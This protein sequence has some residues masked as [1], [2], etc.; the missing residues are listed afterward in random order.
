MGSQNPTLNGRRKF[1][2]ATGIFVDSFPYNCFYIYFMI[3]LTNVVGIN[4][5]L[6]GTIS[7]CSVCV[8][9]VTDP[10]MGWLVDNPKI[11]IKKWMLWGG[12]ATA[13]SICFVF[14]PLYASTA[15]QFVYYVA[16]SGIMWCAYTAFCI[17]YY[18]MVPQMTSDYNE[19]T[20]IRGLSGTINSIAVYG[21]CVLPI[22][23]I[24]AISEGGGDPVMAWFYAA[25]VIGAISLFFTFV[26]YFSVKNV[27]FIETERPDKAENFVKAYGEVFR[28][29]PVKFFLAFVFLFIFGSAMA[30]SNQTYLII[31]AAGADPD[32]LAGTALMTLLAFLI[33]SPVATAISQK[34]DRKVAIYVLLGIAAAGTLIIRIIGI[35]NLTPVYFLTAIACVGTAAFWCLFYTFC[36]DIVALDQY[37][38]GKNREGI[39]TGLPNFILKLANAVGLQT[40]GIILTL[41]GYD[42]TQEAQTERAVSGIV[43][44]STTFFAILMVLAI[45]MMVLYPITKKKYNKLLE[46]IDIKKE[47]PE[48]HDPELDALM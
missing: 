35:H 11:D 8:D 3:F 41:V 48:Y 24:T 25:C 5:A 28:L 26:N 13:V 12:I 43:N 31:Y 42:A 39:I 2:Y 32:S 29:K 20:Q 18:A 30:S 23:V 47:N 44:I 22:L 1:G 17:P 14:Y 15:V 40:I 6:A 38:N 27:K 45:I 37:K 4:P 34:Y 10:I 9:A 46:A 21:G 36:Y 16:V 19:Q 33:I 7:L